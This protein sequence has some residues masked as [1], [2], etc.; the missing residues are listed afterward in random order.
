I[1]T[2]FLDRELGVTRYT[3]PAV[4]LFNLIPTDI[5]RPLAHLTNQLDYPQLES[6]AQRVLKE[7]VPIEREVSDARQRWYLA[8]MLPYRT[9]EDRIAGIVLTLVDISERKRSQRALRMSEER[10]SAVAN[11]AAVGLLQA[12]ISG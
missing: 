4:A 10:F 12:D 1:A 7:L 2:V 11:K 9:S 5:G 3:P 6:D 8:R